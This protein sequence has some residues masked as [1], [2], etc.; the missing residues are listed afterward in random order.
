MFEIESYSF[1]TQ[2]ML[3]YSLFIILWFIIALLLWICNR[4]CGLFESVVYICMCL[5]TEW[6][7]CHLANLFIVLLLS[8]F[9]RFCKR[10]FLLVAW[11]KPTHVYTFSDGMLK[12][13]ILGNCSDDKPFAQNDQTKKRKKTT[14]NNN[15]SDNPQIGAK[16]FFRNI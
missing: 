10:M 2:F 14:Y 11:K 1:H 5:W 12:H 13:N 9:L 8:T 16:E 15:Y 6:S 4:C 3:Y 7:I